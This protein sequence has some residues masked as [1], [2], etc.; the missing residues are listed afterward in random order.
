MILEE[1]LSYRYFSEMDR[2][3]RRASSSLQE[4][5]PGYITR[6][7]LPTRQKKVIRM[8]FTSPSIMS[9]QPTVDPYAIHTESLE[10]INSKQST[11]KSR[12]HSLKRQKNTTAIQ[13]CSNITVENI[14]LYLVICVR[15]W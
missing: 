8:S 15:S 1:N 3:S 9:L 2:I 6:L 12:K 7:L 5:V 14:R 10:Q 4:L 11:A 13:S